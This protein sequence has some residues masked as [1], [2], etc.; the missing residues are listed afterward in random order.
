MTR[1]TAAAGALPASLQA[2]DLEKI[3]FKVVRG[4]WTAAKADRVELLYK[5]YLYLS[6]LYPELPL[7]PTEDVDEFWHNHIL[8]TKKY[9]EDTLR[10]FGY[11]LHHCPY[12]GMTEESDEAE[13][14]RAFQ[15]TAELY[16]A[17]FGSSGP[18][19]LETADPEAAFCGGC[20]SKDV[21]PAALIRGAVPLSAVGRPN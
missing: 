1:A 19:W 18:G 5:R 4:G 7:V 21:V 20:C 3:K 8:D 13:L 16:E 6:L 15:Q 2:L 9:A 14:R 12:F 10:I 17:E 11:F